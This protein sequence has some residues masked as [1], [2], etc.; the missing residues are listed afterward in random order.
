[1]PS[2]TVSDD[3]IL[4]YPKR[5]NE[6]WAAAHREIPQAR[7]VEK[8]LNKIGGSIVCSRNLFSRMR[9]AVVLDMRFPQGADY[10]RSKSGYSGCL[11]TSTGNTAG[12]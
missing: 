5:V 3:A 4:A 7:G 8:V 1:M 11:G 9:V 6:A 12:N 10:V 2:I